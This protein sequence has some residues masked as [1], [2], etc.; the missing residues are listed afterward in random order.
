MAITSQQMTKDLRA[1]NEAVSH[2]ADL[3]DGATKQQFRERSA[4][5]LETLANRTDLQRAQERGVQELS[6]AE[7]DKLA[8][9]NADGLIERARAMRVKE[10]GE[11]ASARR[12][13]DQA[14]ETERRQEGTGG[15]DP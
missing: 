14:I 9:P 5:Y 1:M 6:R 13:A 11:A 3:L 7:V 2:T 4:R 8:G 15:I 10:A 12:L